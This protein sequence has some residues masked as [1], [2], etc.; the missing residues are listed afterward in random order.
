MRLPLK[1]KIIFAP[2]LDSLLLPSCASLPSALLVEPFALALVHV[3]VLPSGGA[4]IYTAISTRPTAI[5]SGWIWRFS[6]VT[7][8]T[9]SAHLANTGAHRS[10]DRLQLR[11]PIQRFID[12]SRHPQL[13]QQHRQFPRHRNHGPLLAVLPTSTSQ[14]QT[15]SS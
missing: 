11:N 14:F 6:A 10:L 2:K 4:A 9:A 1:G 5:S 12:L 8:N 7:R 13:V 3:G 15:P